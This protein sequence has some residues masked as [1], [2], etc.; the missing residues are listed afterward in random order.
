MDIWVEYAKME[1]GFVETLRRRWDTLGIKDNTAM[2]IKTDDQNSDAARQEVLDGAIVKEVLRDA[3]QGKHLLHLSE[4][5]LISPCLYL[6]SSY[7]RCIQKAFAFT[8]AL[9][10]RTITKSG[11]LP[12]RYHQTDSAD[13]P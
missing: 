10:H 6:S 2:D 9:P 7:D 13:Q 3:L 11:F 4:C 8:P 5:F 12:L 1:L